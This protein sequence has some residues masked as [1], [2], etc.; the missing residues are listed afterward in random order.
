MEQRNNLAAWHRGLHGQHY[1]ALESGAVVLD[2][3]AWPRPAYGSYTTPE[4]GPLLAL[5]QLERQLERQRPPQHHGRVR[6]RVYAGNTWTGWLSFWK[7]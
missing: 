1:A 7:W 2:S 4:F 5:L 6:C 3:S